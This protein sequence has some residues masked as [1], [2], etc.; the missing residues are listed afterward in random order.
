[1]KGANFLDE[2]QRGCFFANQRAGL[3]KGPKLLLLS[4]GQH[5]RKNAVL[6]EFVKDKL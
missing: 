3:L 6:L 5:C 2:G 4:K 1:M